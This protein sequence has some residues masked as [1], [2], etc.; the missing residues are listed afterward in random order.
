MS[1]TIQKEMIQQ[2]ERTIAEN[3]QLSW[4][5]FVDKVAGDNE[6]MLAYLPLLKSIPAMDQPFDLMVQ[7][8]TLRGQFASSEQK[9]ANLLVE[10]EFVEDQDYCLLDVDNEKFTETLMFISYNCIKLFIMDKQDTSL[11]RALILGEQMYTKYK[12]YSKAFLKTLSPKTHYMMIEQKVFTNDIIKRYAKDL[13][14][15]KVVIVSITGTLANMKKAIEAMK[16]KPENWGEVIVPL[17]KAMFSSALDDTSRIADYVTETLIKPYKTRMR[18]ELKAKDKKA[19]IPTASAAWGCIARATYMLVSPNHPNIPFTHDDFVQC[20]KECFVNTLA[21]KH[22]SIKNFSHDEYLACIEELEAERLKNAGRYSAIKANSIYFKQVCDAKKVIK[23]AESDA[24]KA[25]KA[26]SDAPVPTSM[27]TVPNGYETN[28]SE[29]EKEETKPTTRGSKKTKAKAESEHVEADSKPE[30]TKKSGKKPSKKVTINESD[31]EEADSKPE[32]AK[33]SGKKSS[34][35]ATEVESEG[36][37]KR[38]TPGS[39]VE[40]TQEVPKAEAK[41]AAKKAPKVVEQMPDSDSDVD[42]PIVA[43]PIE[44]EEVNSDVSD[45]EDEEEEDDQDDQDDQ[46]EDEDDDATSD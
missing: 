43:A 3:S 22:V 27:V 46:D 1:I 29:A 35:K 25:L 18:I 21:Q 9:M 40:I 36:K 38:R 23:K 14:G 15:P 39:K 11:T 17:T 19:K 31:H 10:S 13:G 44:E 30:P 37:P 24:K 26:E 5:E 20:I 2:I 7:F 8:N 34:K 28:G 6:H 45:P 42:A 4:S 32:P 33:K 16:K 12:P 41:P